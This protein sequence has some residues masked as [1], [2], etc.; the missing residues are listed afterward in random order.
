M[1]TITKS[2]LT[3]ALTRLALED[4]RLAREDRQCHH[5]VAR[6]KVGRVNVTYNPKGRTYTMVAQQDLTLTILVENVPS[7]KAAAKLVEVYDV[8]LE[9][10]TVLAG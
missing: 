1:V 5:M 9:D 6:T 10:T 8:H 3:Q 7:R 4:L 2:E